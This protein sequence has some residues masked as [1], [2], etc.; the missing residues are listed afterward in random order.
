M[1]YSSLD[2]TPD[3]HADVLGDPNS[4]RPFRLVDSVIAHNIQRELES[5]PDTTE[6]GAYMRVPTLLGVDRAVLLQPR[7][8]S[9]A[10]SPKPCVVRVMLLPHPSFSPCCRH[11]PHLKPCFSL[12][13]FVSRPVSYHRPPHSHPLCFPRP[14]RIIYPCHELHILCPETRKGGIYSA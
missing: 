3:A 5:H 9:S 12:G 14:L 7:S 4:Y 11:Q 8:P 1:L 6:E 2:E 10:P 13:Q